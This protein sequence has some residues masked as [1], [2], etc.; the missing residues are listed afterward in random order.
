MYIYILPFFKAANANT[1]R[2]NSGIKYHYWTGV[3]SDSL[4]S[5]GST[6]TN[7]LPEAGG[8]V[9]GGGVAGGGG[10]GSG[11]GVATVARH[12]FWLDT[13]SCSLTCC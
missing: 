7:A 5:S 12:F 13:T 2:N 10:G 8:G 11:V 4:S 9:A 6:G 1:I 3:A